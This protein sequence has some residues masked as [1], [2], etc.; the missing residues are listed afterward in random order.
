VNAD[1]ESFLKAVKK[2]VTPA[3]EK[4]LFALG[5]RS[6]YENPASDLL[7]FFLKPDAEHKLGDLFLSTYLECMKENS[8]QFNMRDVKVGRE[9]STAKNN[10]IDLLI[11]ETEWCLVIENKIN[12]WDANDFTDYENHAKRLRKQQLFS[13]L[14]RD[15]HHKDNNGTHWI[16]VSYKDFCHALREKMLATYF[17]SPFSKWHIFAREFILHLENELYLPPMTQEQAAEVEKYAD[18]IAEAEKLAKQYREFFLKELQHHLKEKFPEIKFDTWQDSSWLSFCLLAFRCKSQQWNKNEMILY[19][20]ENQKIF[21]RAYLT[22]VADPLL[23]NARQTLK[24]VEDE[25]EGKFHRWTSLGYN[26]REEAIAKLCE[27]ARVVN[28]LMEK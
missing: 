23:S 27:W 11:L 1:L 15:G 10:Y 26:S 12:H 25:L 3:K 5:G 28:G 8:R 20:P 14:S 6:Y 16:G 19:R 7:A 17:D 9:M 22:N 4:T 24:P 18:Q 21:V 13:I 2:Y